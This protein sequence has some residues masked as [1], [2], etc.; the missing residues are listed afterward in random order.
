M[1]AAAR[2]HPDPL[3]EPR[4]KQRVSSR[5]RR[6]AP[7]Y[8][9]LLKQ[10]TSDW[11]ED[12]AMRL[13][14]SL[15]FYTMLSLAPLLVLAIKVVGQL[16]GQDVARKQVQ[17]YAVQWMGPKAAS[18]VAGMLSYNLGHGLLAT[19][20]SA[21]ILIV[22][23]SAVFGELQDS[24]NT[25]WEVKPKPG[26]GLWGIFQD[27]FLSF[28]LV[29][30]S[31]FLLLVSLIVSTVLAALT[32]HG[33]QQGFLWETFNF[34]ISIAVITTLFALIFKYLPDVKVRWQD[35]WVGAVATGILFTIGKLLLGWYLG[36]ATTTSIYGTAGSAIAVLLWV[37]YSSQILF[38]GAELT[39]AYAHQTRDRVRP[40]ENAVPVTEQERTQQG[41]P[42]TEHVEAATLR[43]ETRSSAASNGHARPV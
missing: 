17:A 37:Y 39:Q 14:A 6:A 34:I 8:W 9:Q 38:F 23:A 25:I 29:L 35:V 30:G 21:I 1:V 13:A 40:T 26:R 33:H 22:S 12:R 42:S 28:V 10:A 2:Q 27:R 11:M 16:F 20:I 18:A 4:A 32:G 7:G 43:E 15:A 31:C 41:M 36:R 24:L 5:W 3:K 19:T